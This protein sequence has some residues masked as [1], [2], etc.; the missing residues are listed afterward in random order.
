[1][2]RS[3]AVIVA[4]AVLLGSVIGIGTYTFIY[5]KGY[6]YLTNN[7]AACANCHV[8]QAQYEAWWKSSHHS[9]ATCNDSGTLFTSPAAITPTPSRSP[10]S[11]TMWRKTPAADVTKTLRRRSTATLC[12][13]KPKGCSVRAATIQS[14]IRNQPLPN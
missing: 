4:L 10:S 3:A 9:V 2:Q 11:I 7:P 13:A 6:S 12:K 14:A 5:A 8:M 1:M